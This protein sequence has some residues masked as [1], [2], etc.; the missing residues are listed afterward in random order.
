MKNFQIIALGVFI[1]FAVGGI[2]FFAAFQGK[3]DNAEAKITLWGLVPGNQMDSLL[4]GLGLADGAIEVTYE[5]KLPESFDRELVEALA[6][7]KGPDMVL[8]PHDML[9]RHEAKIVPISTDTLSERT[10]RDTFI[11]EG[12]LYRT[13]GGALGL[14]F[15]IDPLVMY[16][17]RDMLAGAS[18]AA[19]PKYW[20]EFFDFIPA[21]VQRDDA[22]NLTR[23]AVALGEYAN[24]DHAKAIISALMLQAGNPILRRDAEGT[25]QVSFTDSSSAAGS[26]AE[27]TLR[28]YTEFANPLKPVYTWNRSES[29]SKDAF[30]AGDLALYFGFASELK[31]LRTK[32]PNLNFDV[33]PVPQVRDS[34]TVA[35]YGQMSGFSILKASPYRA[36]SYKAVTMLVSAPAIDVWTKLS[37]LPPVRRDMLSKKPG[38]AYLNVFYSAALASRAW[39]DPDSAKTDAIFARMVEAVTSG[40]L[41][42]TEAVKRAGEETE[43]LLK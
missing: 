30:L 16:F 20:D 15:S 22:G 23:S 12:D 29:R 26:A 27:A 2:I 40:R 19:P 13:P 5:Q 37:N 7:G 6:E 18:I 8:L 10:F 25:P 14:P 3:G 36:E 35:T 31:E 34:R 38:D 28:F 17:N 39:L 4:G 21:I 42:I 41:R 24:I 33:A 9:L 11:E 1:M 43:Q 32:N